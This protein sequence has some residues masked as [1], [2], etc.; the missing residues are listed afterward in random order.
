MRISPICAWP[1]CTARLISFALKSDALECTVILS[2]PA[3]A[4]STSA[5][6]WLMFSVWKLAVGYGVG[7]SHFVCASVVTHALAAMAA[8][9]AWRRFMD[10]SLGV[11]RT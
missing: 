4:L 5:A 8:A 7:M 11:A 9:R 6:N 10:F 1:P 2:L 3:V